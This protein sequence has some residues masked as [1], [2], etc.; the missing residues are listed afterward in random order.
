LLAFLVAASVAEAA[1]TTPPVDPGALLNWQ[2]QQTRI[3][4]QQPWL[5]RPMTEEDV[6]PPGQ[7]PEVDYQDVKR[8]NVRPVGPVRRTSPPTQNSPV[9]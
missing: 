3:R 4:Q 1:P 7:D 5:N 2:I 9:W 8:Q 6:M